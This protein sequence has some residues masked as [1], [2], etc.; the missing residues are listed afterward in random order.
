M[1]IPQPPKIDGVTWT[2]VRNAPFDRY[3]VWYGECPPTWDEV[4]IVSG[5]SEI[6]GRAGVTI[7]RGEITYNTRFPADAV[8]PAIE[9]A[10]RLAAE[11][12][13]AELV[14]DAEKR[15]RYV[16]KMGDYYRATCDKAR[17]EA[18]A[19]W[20]EWG[21][22]MSTWRKVLG[23][24]EHD[25]LYANERDKLIDAVRKTRIKALEQKAKKVDGGVDWR[26]SA[27][28]AAIRFLTEADSD[29]ASVRNARGWG[30]AHSSLGHWCYAM[31]EKDP[32]L[33]IR[34]ARTIVGE[35][36]HT[37]LAAVL[38]A[39]EHAHHNWSHKE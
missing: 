7:R 20:A 8:G 5:Y 10:R 17:A 38:R 4:K 35:Y 37:Q 39:E 30:A 31:L 36:E 26:D 24:L 16:E 1:A 12:Q 21:H 18:E 3:K 11:H 22:F 14:T 2:D 28:I 32:A 9:K 25:H 13:Q 6:L 23:I 19:C 33:A 34:H 27:V 29:H 15:R